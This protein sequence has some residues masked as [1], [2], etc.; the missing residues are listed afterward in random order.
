MTKLTIIGCKW[1]WRSISIGYSGNFSSKDRLNNGLADGVFGSCRSKF[2]KGTED[3]DIE[4]TLV[5]ALPVSW[6]TAQYIWNTHFLLEHEKI[7]K[8]VSELLF[9]RVEILAAELIFVVITPYKK[10]AAMKK[11]YQSII[12]R[13]L[14]IFGK[15]CRKRSWMEKKQGKLDFPKVTAPTEFSRDG[16]LHEVAWLIACD[17]Q[18]KNEFDIFKIKADEC[19]VVGSGGQGSIP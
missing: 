5:H 16:V 12:M 4:R 19:K 1:P 8:A 6:R 10:S 17:D 3:R 14:V 15:K 13:F 7:L 2:Q 18:V 9:L 11:T